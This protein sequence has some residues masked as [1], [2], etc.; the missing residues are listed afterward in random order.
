M[1]VLC[2]GW[3]STRFTDRPVWI[4]PTEVSCKDQGDACNLPLESS[5]SGLGADSQKSHST[6][7]GTEK[8]CVGGCL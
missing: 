8:V 3:V 5:G 1:L 2:A 6:A 7:F 4:A